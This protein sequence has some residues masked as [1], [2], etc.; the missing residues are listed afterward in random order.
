[1]GFRWTSIGTF[2]PAD[3]QYRLF[4]QEEQYYEGVHA[5]H[6]MP[7]FPA[8]RMRMMMAYFSMNNAMATFTTRTVLIAVVVAVI[9]IKERI[10][11]TH[12]PSAILQKRL[13]L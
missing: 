3:T 1:M 11:D 9:W 8:D 7:T 13:L 4:R 10:V 2:L 6:A 5:C 12:L